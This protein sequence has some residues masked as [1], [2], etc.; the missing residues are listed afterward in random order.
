MSTIQ[1]HNQFEGLYREI[2]DFKTRLQFV[3]DEVKFLDHLLNAYEFQP[4]T[5]NLFERLQLFGFQLN[6]T[7]K[8]VKTLLDRISKHDLVLG[9]MIETNIAEIDRTFYR[10]HDKLLFELKDAIT[11]F[12]NLKIEIFN[13]VLGLLRKKK[14]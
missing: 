6:D 1:S 14:P 13:Y 8:K 5:Q 12:H 4:T 11:D 2:H 3:L 10:Q 7:T 9:G